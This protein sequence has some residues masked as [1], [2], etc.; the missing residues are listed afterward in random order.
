MP[1]ERKRR[2]G[3]P[4]KRALPKEGTITILPPAQVLDPTGELTGLEL[5]ERIASSPAQHWIAEQDKLGLLELMCQAWDERIELKQAMVD[6]AERSLDYSDDER[7]RWTRYMRDETIR[8]L[9][10]DVRRLEAQLT[11]WLSLL[12]LTPV[13]RTRMGVAEVGRQSRLEELK[14]RRDRQLG[15][16]SRSRTG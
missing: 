15:R 8:A 6:A 10:A 14:Q 16:G 4:G 11:Q 3:N 13:D 7:R 9:R 12:G 1:L 5:R 2:L